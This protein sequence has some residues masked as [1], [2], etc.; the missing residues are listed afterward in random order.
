MD[1]M[2]QDTQDQELQD[3]PALPATTLR[4]RPNMVAKQAVGILDIQEQDNTLPSR[5]R[6][7]LLQEPWAQACLR[8]PRRLLG[9]LPV[10]TTVLL[11]PVIH[12]AILPRMSM[13]QRL[14]PRAPGYQPPWHQLQA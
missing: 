2:N 7:T 9:L 5:I 10:P 13:L 4:P 1:M 14:V 6:G 12:E 11:M 3:T 8:S